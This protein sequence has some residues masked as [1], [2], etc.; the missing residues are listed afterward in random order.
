MSNALRLAIIF[1]IAV[2]ALAAPG[3]AHPDHSLVGGERAGPGEV[4]I[5][6]MLDVRRDRIRLDGVSVSVNGLS[7]PVSVDGHFAANVPIAPYYRVDIGGEKVFAMVQTFGNAELRDEQCECLVIP[8][9]ELLARK[10]GRIELFFGGDSMAGRRYFKAASGKPAV[11]DRATLDRDLDALFTAM[12][13]YIA[14]SDLASINLESVVSE[15]QPGTP[16]PKKFVFYSP[17]ELT[18]A[19][20]R[21]GIDH[22]ALGNNHTADYGDE[23][24]NTTIDALDAAGVAWS[25]A[26]MN[27][28]EA[29][30]ASR[31]KVNGKK[32]GIY[33]FVGWRGTW[34]PNQTAS[35]TKAGAA[36]GP[37]K[38]VE[39]VTTR[40]RRAGYTPIMH[41][42]GNAEYGDRSSELSVPRFRAAI[43]QSAPVVIGHHPHV[44]HGLE[45]YR[46]GLI[47]HSLGNFLFDQDRPQTQV[48]YALKVWLERGK[49]LR[50]EAIPLN[51]LDYRPVPAIGGMREASLRRLHWLSAEMGT[52]M[53]RSGGHSVVWRE[54]EGF[55]APDCRTPA[56]FKLGR[57]APACLGE[58]IT[59]GRNIIPRGDFE[60]ARFGEATERF[61]ATRNAAIDFRTSED[62]EGYIALL[63]DS[64]SKSA[65]LYSRSYIRD[66]YATHFTWEGRIKLPR[67]A[68]VELMAKMQPEAG[69][70][71]TPST[72]GVSLGT[73]QVGADGWQKLHFEFTRPEEGE[74]A[75]RAF[76]IIMKIRFDDRTAAGERTIELD[77]L[78]LIEWP[79]EAVQ[80]DPANA[81]RWTH[82]RER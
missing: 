37:R 29:E 17:P 78:A 2:L 74:G 1:T 51:I 76:R 55:E 14:T 64:L 66:I 61:W 60:N 12:K 62:G 77:D 58:N 33:S 69:A 67:G 43:E 15:E 80:R 75:A 39:R 27:I 38:R 50:A 26:G 57:F 11:L 7:A 52:V 42:H 59:H 73:Q 46:G 44:T 23:G 71:P 79:N 4:H 10:K 30:R 48:S 21:A 31:L 18:N 35:E 63:P 28:D 25:G 68:Q 32:L 19:L 20:R 45:I 36:W 40:E 9:I 72:R 5:A 13:P 3:N 22:V 54:R 65:Y 6:G 70:K 81:W 56:Q 8:P 16:S 34:T 82:Q 49:F 47:A 53:A 24:V 41:F